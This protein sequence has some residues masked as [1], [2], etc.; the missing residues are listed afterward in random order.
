MNI[1]ARL[2]SVIDRFEFEGTF[3]AC[4]AIKTGHI[5]RTYRLDYRQA[6]GAVRSYLLQNINTFAFK[7]PDELMENVRLVTEHLRSAY[8]ARGEDA[9][10]RVLRVVPVKDGGILL[11]DDEGNAW[12]AYDF[13][14]HA[15]SIDKVESPAQFSEIGRAFGQFQGMLADFPIE[16]LHD[17]IPDFH[18][19]KKRLQA[20]ETAVAR[21]AAGRAASVPDE[22]AFVRARG[23]EMGRIVDMIEAG[24]I[25][26]RVTHND[27]KINNV[28][29]DTDTGEAL[30]VIDLDTV[31][32]GSALYDFGDAIRYGAS[33]A[34]EDE[35]DLSK[36][37]LDI[38]LFRGFADGFISKTAGNLT[39]AELLNL[40]LGALV[41]TYENG[42]RFLTDYLDGDV[43]FHIDYPDHNLAR[44][45]AQFTLLSD[46]ESR[47]DEMDAIV[48]ELVQKYRKAGV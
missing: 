28:M 19:T 34:A 1:D 29:L 13:I 5:N 32:A 38:D 48:R 41:M 24:A 6:D 45:R 16:K 39:E 18:D 30:C 20:F 44:A 17:T 2:Q 27:T 36:V 10:N 46:M 8:I 47:R 35:T 7:K 23:T 33:T 26:L 25:P 31:M 40:P 37:A 3:M 42:M 11:L 43:Y 4:E 9:G 14:T 21:D 12:R 15:A 22:I